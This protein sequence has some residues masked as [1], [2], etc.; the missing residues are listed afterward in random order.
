MPRKSREFSYTKESPHFYI[1]CK[2]CGSDE[3]YFHSTGKAYN[4]DEEG[5]DVTLHCNNCGELNSIGD[6]CNIEIEED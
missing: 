4:H 3:M 1:I 6:Y 5:L 2:K